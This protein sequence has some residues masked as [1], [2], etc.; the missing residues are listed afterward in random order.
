MRARERRG[1]ALLAVG[2]PDAAVTD[3]QHLVAEHPLRERLWARLVT[4]LYA[5]DRQAEA[6]DA[7]RRCADLLREELGIDPGPELRDLERAVL[8]QDPTTARPH[9]APPHAGDARAVPACRSP[10][11][12]SDGGPSSPICRRSPGR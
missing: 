6:L 11:D 9:P 12:S 2:R 1:D 10:R 7:L 4:A 3:L 8:N 5:A